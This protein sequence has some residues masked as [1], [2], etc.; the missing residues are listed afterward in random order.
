MEEPYESS[1]PAD[2]GEDRST[3]E[4]TPTTAPL[5]EATGDNTVL[6]VQ[7]LQ[8]I[9]KFSRA[10]VNDRAE[11][12]KV[13]LGQFGV[14]ANA[15]GWSQLV[16]LVELTTRLKGPSLEYYRTCPSESKETY[17]KLNE[18]LSSHFVLVQLQTVQSCQFLERKQLEGES[19]DVYTQD[20]H[21]LFNLAYPDAV[22]GTSADG[23]MGRLVLASQFVTRLTTERTEGEAGWSRRYRSTSHESQI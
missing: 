16:R 21:C 18:S 11:L 15:F 2:S 17:N 22:K 20:L 12:F 6:L 8:L 19:V 13:W 4:M 23:K 5:S 10:N 14:I 3:L 1:C 9:E 7:Q